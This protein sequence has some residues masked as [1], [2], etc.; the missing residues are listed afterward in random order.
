[1]SLKQ[2]GIVVIKILDTDEL[3]DFNKKIQKLDF[4]EFTDEYKKSGKPYVL[5]GF[6]GFGHPSSFHHPVIRE[7]RML[8]KKRISNVF[9]NF[10]DL[11]KQEEYKLEML[12]DRLCERKKEF[13]NPKKESWHQDICEIDTKD[14]EKDKDYIF[15]GWI[16]LDLENIQTFLGLNKTF[17]IKLSDKLGF[18]KVPDSE[19]PKYDQLL[20]S[21]GPIKVEPGHCIIIRQGT[22][23]SI[24]PKV[25]KFSSFRLFTG[26][27]LTKSIENLFDI[28]KSIENLEVPQIPSGQIPTMY[29]QMHLVF[30]PDKINNLA[31]GLKYEFKTKYTYKSGVKKGLTIDSVKKNISLKSLSLKEYEYS[32]KDKLVLSPEK[33]SEI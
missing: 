15:G 2:D 14:K 28:S 7:L 16:N 17:E 4:P 32:E 11:E 22:I 26:F 1:M 8:I 20:K 33:F 25:P 19:I 21:Q 3:K 31:S 24:Q 5:G 29:E 10:L 13:G 18:A 6:G 12:F 30:W 27:R 23:H 9:K